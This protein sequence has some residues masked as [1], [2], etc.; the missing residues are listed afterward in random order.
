M[1]PHL[2]ARS[3]DSN[4]VGENVLTTDWAWWKKSIDANNI[5][6]Y[7]PKLNENSKVDW[8]AIAIFP[9]NLLFAPQVSYGCS[10][11]TQKTH[12]P[13]ET[14]ELDTMFPVITGAAWTTIPRLQAVNEKKNTK[15]VDLWSLQFIHV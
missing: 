2:H 6:K 3:I 8:P 10:N 12:K 14:E 9:G 15:Y 11:L 5:F 7:H 1:D 13:I 4:L